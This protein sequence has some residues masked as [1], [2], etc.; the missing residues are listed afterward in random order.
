MT[1]SNE[2]TKEVI[3]GQSIATVIEAMGHQKE[4]LIKALE[5]AL[6]RAQK[7]QLLRPDQ[8]ES[9]RRQY[10]RNLEGYTYL[11]ANDLP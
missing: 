10:H 7:N 2:V 5:D 1:S 9:L 6:L 3:P 8:A 11:E 4:A